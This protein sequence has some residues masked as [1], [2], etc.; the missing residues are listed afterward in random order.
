LG[1]LYALDEMIWGRLLSNPSPETTKISEHGQWNV[2][3]D[4]VRLDIARPKHP[5]FRV[6][7]HLPALVRAVLQLAQRGSQ[8]RSPL[9]AIYE[10]PSIYRAHGHAGST[11]PDLLGTRW[12]PPEEQ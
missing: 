11:D 3:A 7:V 10:P 9:L 1:L 6:K 2:G 12:P 4:S 8:R 5:F